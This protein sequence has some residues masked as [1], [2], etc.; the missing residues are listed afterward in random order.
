M[1]FEFIDNTS[2]KKRTSG[3]PDALQVS[4]PSG[5]LLIEQVDGHQEAIKRLRKIG[6]VDVT[7]HATM[8]LDCGPS[9]PHVIRDIEDLCTLLSFAR[10]TKINWAYLDTLS[11]SGEKLHTRHVSRV[12]KRFTSFPL[13][14]PREPDDLPSLL[15]CFHRFREAE[16]AHSLKR[17]VD[18]YTD[19]KADQAFLEARGMLAAILVDFLLGRYRTHTNRHS[20]RKDFNRTQAQRTL[21]KGLK[22]LLGSV[23]SDITDDEEKQFLEN[24]QSL[25]RPAFRRVLRE[26]ADSLGVRTSEAEI[27][28]ITDIR[29]SLVHSASFLDDMV[30][31]DQYFQLINFLDKILLAILGY[32]GHYIDCTHNWQRTEFCRSQPDD[33]HCC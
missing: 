23:F 24:L 4:L 9:L 5:E 6:G 17:V 14:D 33:E 29:N 19:A 2:Q 16:E 31:I 25:N 12:T 28:R 18:H 15:S 10:G 30:N 7:C 1:N 8:R 13:I 22:E 21:R 3:F 26:F 32:Q 20:I 27:R 11:D